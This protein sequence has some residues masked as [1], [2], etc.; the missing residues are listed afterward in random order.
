MRQ[1]ILVFGIV[2]WLIVVPVL[3][4]QTRDTGVSTGISS[5]STSWTS[6]SFTIASNSDILLLVGIKDRT[7][8]TDV[9]GCNWDLATPEALTQL[10]TLSRSG[11]NNTVHIWYL[12]NPTPGTDTVT[13][14]HSSSHTGVLGVEVWYD[15][16]QTTT[17]RTVV[18][19]STSGNGE[20][21]SVTLS[22]AVSGD[23]LFDVLSAGNTNDQITVAPTADGSQTERWMI[24]FIASFEYYGAG[25]TLI[26]SGGDSMGWSW[27]GTDPN[28]CMGVPII[29]ASSGGTPMHHYRRMR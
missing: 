21:C 27:T 26:A 11:S 2:A 28:V 29:P 6:P 23:L 7:G 5:G 22:S 17:F 8:G 24:E 19:S 16:D 13:C 9:T 10:D 4:A 15:I 3:S 25:S 14:T 12:K 18:K 1:V 20:A